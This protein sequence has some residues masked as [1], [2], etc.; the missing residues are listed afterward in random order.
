MIK[1]SSMRVSNR[2]IPPSEYSLNGKLDK[3]TPFHRHCSVPSPYVRRCIVTTRV[4]AGR[5][6]L[7]RIRS[8]SCIKAE[9]KMRQAQW[10]GRG[11]TPA[12]LTADRSIM[13]RP[14][15]GSFLKIPNKLVAISG[16]SLPF[17]FGVLG[18]CSLYLGASNEDRVTGAWP[19]HPIMLMPGRRLEAVAREAGRL[20][21]SAG[22]RSSAHGEAAEAH[23]L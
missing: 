12:F 7:M 4:S 6:S 22:G 10:I 16:R 11:P 17:T 14:R 3:L 8:A 23:V 21:G 9:G 1:L 2:I 18:K 13:N 20:V 19:S 5:K 15:W